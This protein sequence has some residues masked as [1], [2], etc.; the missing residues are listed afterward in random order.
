QPFLESRR[1]S[2]VPLE[3]SL[4]SIHLVLQGTQAISNRTRIPGPSSSRLRKNGEGTGS[5]AR[6]R[7]VWIRRVGGQ[8]HQHVGNIVCRG[9]CLGRS[10]SQRVRPFDG[11][12]QVRVDAWGGRGQ[13]LEGV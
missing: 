5:R 3:V 6:W 13:S 9:R 4:N 2:V 12:H 11:R 10:S 7:K 1:M 8:L